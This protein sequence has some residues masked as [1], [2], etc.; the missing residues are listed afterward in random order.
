MVPLSV[1][2]HE[3]DLRQFEALL[4]VA[5]FVSL[6]SEPGAFLSRAVPKLCELISF[7]FVNLALPNF[8]EKT[9][10]MFL[11]ENGPQ[12]SLDMPVDQTAVGWVWQ[13]QTV[14]SIDDLHNYERDLA[15][16]RRLRKNGIQSY[17]V[18]PL[19]SGGEKLG[20]LGFG[21][22][23]THAFAALE[24]EFLQRATELSALAVNGQ[25]DAVAFAQE[26]SRLRMLIELTNP[27]LKELPA[28]RSIQ[29]ILRILRAWAP[30]DFFGVYIFDGESQCLRL[31]TV[32]EHLTGPLPQDGMAPLDSTL[33]GQVFRTQQGV[34]L[35]E[36]A[37][38]VL[39]F[40]SVKQW[41][42]LG[43]KAVYLAPLVFQG[44]AMGVFKVSRREQR[45]FTS[46][47]RETLERVTAKIVPILAGIMN[48]SFL[49][50]GRPSTSTISGPGAELE[51]PLASADLANLF[52]F[53]SPGALAR[54]AQ[55]LAAYFNASEVGLCILD[56]HFAYVAVNDAL[57]GINGIP[58]ADHIGKTVRELLG[59]FAELI[60][61][62]FERVLITGE[63][64]LNLEISSLI[65]T[66]GKP[67]HWR[68]HYVPL[69]DETGKV[70]QIGVAVVE[71]T[72]KRR[73]EES[74]RDIS[75]TLQQEKQRQHVMSEIT[76]ILAEKDVQAAF[77]QIS[78][79]LRR[80]L[81]QEYA[82]LA[83]RE[84]DTGKLVRLALDFPLR[85]GPEGE[86]ELSILKDR[87]GRPLL[88]RAPLILGSEQMRAFSAPTAN[89]FL[90]EG[91][92]SLCLVPLLR[93]TRSL[94]VLTLGSTRLDAFKTD[95]LLLL[96]QVAAQLAI[97]LENASTAAEIQRLRERLEQEKAYLDKEVRTHV[98]FD[99]IVGQSAALKR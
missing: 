8:F 4:S 42:L 91:M 3:F 97:S 77:P 20:A 33:S 60:E 52:S 65:P 24:I 56:S 66:R 29:S 81:H 96:N 34:I 35:D 63:P 16:L 86:P 6:R 74:L 27:A 79:R 49:A 84:Q 26:C 75:E 39:P 61:P 19:I 98:E 73:L 82:A 54:S 32:K 12:E 92:K 55:L 90:A 53:A 36:P 62:Q 37:L 95:D 94:G 1:P 13:T 50:P 51:T 58:A 43:V 10:K 41:M 5:D 70:T 30:R 71:I 76:R 69:R 28:D 38:S 68:E 14:L 44:N 45:P 40:P 64:I 89:Q 83:V 22:K 59:D 2:Q 9:M 23:Q 15:G 93:P 18:L 72:E 11:W 17:C 25:I 85:K 99:E 31:H 21:S 88:E 47:D 67:G 46:F 78:A 80:L 57:A 48:P 7:D 87:Q